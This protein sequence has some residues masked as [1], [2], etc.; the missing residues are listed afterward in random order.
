MSESIKRFLDQ[1]QLKDQAHSLSVAQLESIHSS[2]LALI[3]ERK[4]NQ[5]EHELQRKGERA[6][7]DM[8]GLMAKAGISM[9]E[10]LDALDSL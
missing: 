2:M 10:F 6:L 8:R 9:S 1:S 7:K 4:A 5:Q 3:E